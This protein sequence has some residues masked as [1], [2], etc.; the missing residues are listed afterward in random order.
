MTFKSDMMP[1]SS[2]LE[3]DCTKLAADAETEDDE[4]LIAMVRVSKVSLQATE[5]FRHLTD[6]SEAGGHAILHISPLQKTLDELKHAFSDKQ[7]QHQTILAY[8]YAAEVAIYELAVLHPPTP[9]LH[10][11]A[12]FDHRRIEYL[13]AC[14]QSCKLC[15]E[16]YL[17]SDLIHMTMAS[18][19]IF[20]YCLKLLHKLSTFQDP[21]WDTAIVRRTVDLV[22]LMHNCAAVADQCNARLKEET[23]EDSV[24]LIAA[25]TLRDTAPS[26][27]L[28]S[29]QEPQLNGDAALEGW[30][31]VEAMDLPPID[32]SDDFWLNAAYN[33]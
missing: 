6:G 9:S 7:K 17:G 20:S 1:W 33:H 22:E 2:Q 28:T 5:V 32:F 10:F 14:V 30:A 29:A 3:E 27:R 11:N 4:I 31:G 13:M 24:F 19:L 25:K 26:W 15:V 23:G 16:H 21:N 8:L 18:G 12:L